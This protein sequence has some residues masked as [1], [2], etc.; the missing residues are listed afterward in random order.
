MDVARWSAPAWG[1]IAAAIVYVGLTWWW[2]TQDKSVPVYDAGAHL[3]TV[4]LFRGMIRSG[5]LLGPFNFNEVYPPLGYV[6]AVLASLIGGVNVASPIV[7]ENLVFVPLLVLGCYQTGRLLFGPTAGMLAAIFI[8]GSPLLISQFHVFMLDAP[9]TSLVA[10]SIWLIL[11]SEDFTRIRVAALAGLAVGL[12]ILIKV[13]FPLFVS[14][15]V[16]VVLL[17]G[18]WRNWR[19][20]AIFAL[21]ALVIVAPW[22]GAHISEFGR[23]AEIAGTGPGAGV[24]PG[25]GPP[26][27]SV[28][29]LLWYFWSIL[30]SQLLAPLFVLVVGGA[31][32]MAVA[33]VRKRE[34]KG[35]R[36]EFLIAVPMTWLIVTISPHHDIRYGM[37]LLAYLAVLGTG[38]IVGLARPWRRL[39][40]AVLLLG[41]TVNTLAMTVG[42]GVGRELTIPLTHPLPPTQQVADRIILYTRNG[43]LVS[44]PRR[45]GDIPGL[46]SAL[47]RNGVKTVSWAFEQSRLAD[48]SFEGL[49]PLA[50][51]AGLTPA[52]TSTP[53]FSQSSA[54]ATLIHQPVAANAP[55]ACARLSDGTGVWVVR[56][57]NAR[58]KLALYCPARHPQFYGLGLKI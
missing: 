21:V 30:N 49:L 10:V 11:A 27:L 46:L 24:P 2:L 17:C 44:S 55:P 1:A 9:M 7:G 48:F 41:V 23:I 13:Q 6:P 58:R 52:L 38:W 31:L 47:R 37:P 19:G 29:N 18:G 22:Y 42:V 39:A 26:T 35:V 20:F 12:G 33:L 57:D 4:F 8:L 15:L 54:V 56:Y 51:I 53:E 45:D 34:T 14:G 16:L 25:N 28:T 43:F 36:F 3:E 5:N 32:S 50:Q 40:T